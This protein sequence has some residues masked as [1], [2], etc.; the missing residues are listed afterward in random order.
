M[1]FIRFLPPPSQSVLKTTHPLARVC[2]TWHFPSLCS[3]WS[4]QS[5]RW[6]SPVAPA[7]SCRR[8]D[9]LSPMPTWWPTNI[10]SR[11]A[12]QGAL[13]LYPVWWFIGAVLGES[14]LTST[15]QVEL[16]SGAT[17]DAKIKDVDEKADIAL[18]KIDTPVRRGGVGRWGWGWG[19]SL[20]AEA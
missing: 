1:L 11:Y 5:A 6:P 10:E 7:S 17:F 4:S 9:S 18:I 19:E 8:T 12:Q 13:F 3:G 16:K 20:A 2:F 14:I 15:L